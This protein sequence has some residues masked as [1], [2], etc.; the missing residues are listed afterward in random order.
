MPDHMGYE[1]A[2]LTPQQQARFDHLSETLTELLNAEA[3]DPDLVIGVLIRVTGNAVGHWVP[4]H[5]LHHV[6]ERIGE[7]IL[8]QAEAYQTRPDE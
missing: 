8:G 4:A 1:A 2:G 5:E 3:D 7:G 6:V